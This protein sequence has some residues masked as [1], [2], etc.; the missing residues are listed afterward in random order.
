MDQG[1]VVLN[2]VETTLMLQLDPR[3]APWVWE[4][5]CPQ[6]AWPGG[7][8]EPPL[9]AAAGVRSTY[10]RSPGKIMIE[11]LE[12]YHVVFMG[13]YQRRRRTALLSRGRVHGGVLQATA[14][15]AADERSSKQETF[16]RHT[17]CFAV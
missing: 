11:L 6:T 17:P 3:L 12:P 1:L 5:P 13:E 4:R 10:P 15:G 7:V 14:G 8:W 16:R 9:I 2:L